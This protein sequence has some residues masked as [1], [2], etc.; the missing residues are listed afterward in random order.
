[1]TDRG[2]YR[3]CAHLAI[4]M[5]LVMLYI[6]PSLRVNWNSAFG[7]KWIL[8]RYAV[9]GFINFHLF[10]L[11]VFAA[12][13]LHRRKQHGKAVAAVSGLVIAFCLIKYGV[14]NIFPDEVLQKAVA[15]IGLKKTYFTFFG[16]F[17]LCLQTGLAVTAV[18]YAYYIFLSWR[19]SDQK[20]RLLQKA[21]TDAFRQYERMRFSSVLLLRKLRALETMLQDENKRDK[22]GVAAILQLSDLL[23]YMLYDKAAQQEKAPLEKELQYYT[24]YVQLHNQLFPQQTVQLHIEGDP[25]GLYIEPLLLQTA[26]E[27]LL[28]EQNEAAPVTLRLQIAPDNLALSLPRQGSSQWQRIW[29]AWKGYQAMYRF[30]TP[31]YAEAV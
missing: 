5:A 16:Y 24:T 22:E 12:M 13:P 23:R 28:Q 19:S 20:S 27:K 21:A 8:I 10:Y 2:P 15:L 25:Q 1:M 3:Y 11:L 26:T 29:A 9:Y 18:A 7:M 14:G 4:W 17:R 6:F 31:L 30:K